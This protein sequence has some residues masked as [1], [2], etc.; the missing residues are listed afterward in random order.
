MK[1]KG[2]SD[3]PRKGSHARRRRHTFIVMATASLVTI[4][5]LGSFA[6][7]PL[8]VAAAKSCRAPTKS[9]RYPLSAG[10]SLPHFHVKVGQTIDITM[11]A[12]RPLRT[13][14]YGGNL[15]EICSQVLEA[16]RIV[17]FKALAT[18][19]AP[20]ESEPQGSPGGLLDAIVVVGSAT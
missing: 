1:P 2:L 13:L 9:G 11:P 5:G 4:V 3:G 16:K 6:H 19:A 7:S 17:Q 12:T 20:M 15:H 18:G 8:A 14:S 10:R